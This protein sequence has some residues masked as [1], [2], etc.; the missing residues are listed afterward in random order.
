M[1]DKKANPFKVRYLHGRQ[2]GTSYPTGSKGITFMVGPDRK[3][4]QELLDNY[5]N[6]KIGQLD[7]VQWIGVGDVGKDLNKY[8]IRCSFY[9]KR[10]ISDWL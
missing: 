7:L 2:L 3:A 5:C 9:F 1:L 4:V 10:V 8:N 6:Y